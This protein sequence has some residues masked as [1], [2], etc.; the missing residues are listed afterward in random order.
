MGTSKLQPLLEREG[1][2]RLYLYIYIPLNPSTS[3]KSSN[4][5][6][7]EPW[8]L[9]G[10]INSHCFAHV[11]RCSKE[12]HL[13][14]TTPKNP[15][16]HTLSLGHT[17]PAQAKRRTAELESQLAELRKWGSSVGTTPS[18]KGHQRSVSGFGLS[19]VQSSFGT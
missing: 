19:C 17:E 13:K 10:F 14:R 7:P 1:V 15:P 3:S 8:E 4:V 18:D 12:K 16:A 11:F 6:R 5:F 2:K 9:Q